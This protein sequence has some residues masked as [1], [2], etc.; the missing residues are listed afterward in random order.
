MEGAL[1]L[2]TGR[3]SEAFDRLAAADPARSQLRLPALL[4]AAAAAR[5]GR[6]ADA[7]Q[8]L[9]HAEA[10]PKPVGYRFMTAWTEAEGEGVQ[11]EVLRLIRP[12]SELKRD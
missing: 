10:I 5:A 3:P 11:E 4:T 7:R 6:L 9:S 1:L 12:A 8:W 2:R